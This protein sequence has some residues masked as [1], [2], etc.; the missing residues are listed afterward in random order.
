MDMANIPVSENDLLMAD[1]TLTRVA[2][3]IGEQ[4]LID[5]RHILTDIIRAKRVAALIGGSRP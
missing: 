4:C 5:S 1:E 3:F 2:Q